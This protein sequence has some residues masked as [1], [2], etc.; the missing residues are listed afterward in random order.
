MRSAAGVLRFLDLL[1]SI[2]ECGLH[3]TDQ[4]VLVEDI[5]D[6]FL[7]VHVVLDLA[8]LRSDRIESSL[9]VRSKLVVL[10]TVLRS[11]L[12]KLEEASRVVVDIGVAEIV[13]LVT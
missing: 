1:S 8:A 11:V 13:K 6:A 2:V 12:I 9:A 5:K 3:H 7:V 4:V 10:G